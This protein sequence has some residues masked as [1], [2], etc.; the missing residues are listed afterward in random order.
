MKLGVF[1]NIIVPILGIDKCT[2]IMIS[3]PV[4]EL[5]YF[6]R[7]LKLK[8]PD[9][10][11]LFIKFIFEL[12]CTKCKKSDQPQNCRHKIHCLP[13]WKS[14]K[15][16]NVIQL[17]LEDQQT[18]FLREQ[19]GLITSTKGKVFN[20]FIPILSTKEEITLSSTQYPSF[21]L[22]VCDPNAE[23]SETSSEM[24]IISVCYNYAS[25]FMVRSK[26]KKKKK[27]QI[28]HFFFLF[29]VR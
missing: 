12:V 27:K 15:K 17:I 19:M 28:I 18:S 2:I 9:G 23:D 14:K 26:K 8:S 22:T 24:A 25:C 11:D 13:R 21:V 4:D 7:L 5:N 20:D 1:Y 10:N 6:S 3:S 16:M 29:N